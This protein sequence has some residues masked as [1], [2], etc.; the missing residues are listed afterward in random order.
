MIHVNKICQ[1]FTSYSGHYNNPTG[2]AFWYHRPTEK[3]FW[4]NQVDVDVVT[5]YYDWSSPFASPYQQEWIP[6]PQN[7]EEDF[8]REF[9]L[10]MGYWREIQ[11][12]EKNGHSA[13]Y[14]FS[15]ECELHPAWF[16]VYDDFLKKRLVPQVIEWCKAHGLRYTMDP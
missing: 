3:L 6:L 16:S 11:E 12:A 8:E 2:A 14:F 7:N 13:S 5:Q 1:Y 10:E 15:R 9:L 4:S